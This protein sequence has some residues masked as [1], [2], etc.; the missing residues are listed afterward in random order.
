MI[1]FKS[2]QIK[3]FP[4]EKWNDKFHLVPEMQGK[5]GERRKV[6]KTYFGTYI[7]VEF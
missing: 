2:V 5:L 7:K 3:S 1:M 4:V 6:S